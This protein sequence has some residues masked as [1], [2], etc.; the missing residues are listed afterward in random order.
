MPT[1]WSAAI[2]RLWVHP[3]IWM[4]LI[5]SLVYG[6]F[7]YRYSLNFGKNLSG[8]ICLGDRFM[9]AER[10]PSG[11]F[12]LPQSVGYD[13]TFFYMMAFDPLI[14]G[15]MQAFMDEP[16][17]RYQ[18]I[19]YPALVWL[20]ALGQPARFAS[21]M[22]AVNLL[23]VLAGMLGVASLCR[24]RQCSQWVALFYGML[25]GLAIGI[26]RDLA[27]PTAM[28]WL[29][30]A[31][32][33]F[34]T[35]RYWLTAALMTAAILSREILVVMLPVFC[36]D[37][38]VLNRDWRRGW[39][40]GLAL[41]PALGWQ[42]YVTRRIGEA[43]WHGG[44]RN[45]GRPLH[46]MVQHA[47]EVLLSAQHA[48][49]EQVYLALFLSASLSGLLLA[50]WQAWRRRDAISFGF[51]GFALMPL[52]M[53]RFVWVE[54]WSYGRVLLPGAVFVVLSFVWSRN[55]W[56]LVPLGI[57]A[58]LFWVFMDWNRLIWRGHSLIE[59]IWTRMT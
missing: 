32:V 52:F 20:V 28:A 22:V 5:V 10:V 37:A 45:L 29:V 31:V 7:I 21:A 57:H 35:K 30:W 17:Y 26:F 16:A 49:A 55:R 39:V 46:A 44:A 54:P 18:R 24:H 19:G 38:M 1:Q 3:V 9:P 40:P 14:R 53:T 34:M 33:A 59:H 15:D 50:L 11:T 41:L 8:L 51:L 12:V 27:G 42:L 47:Q 58:A 36:F 2:R 4:I 13:G 56:H 23:A 6:G 43:P 48:P 25:S